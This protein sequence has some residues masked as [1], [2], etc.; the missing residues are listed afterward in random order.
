MHRIPIAVGFCSV[1]LGQNGRME[2]NLWLSRGNFLA[3]RKATGTRALARVIF[4]A[5]GGSR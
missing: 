5:G 2:D 4:Q 1:A 3:V